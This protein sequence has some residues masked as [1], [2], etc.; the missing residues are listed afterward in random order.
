MVVVAG[1]VKLGLILTE[2]VG[3]VGESS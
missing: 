3:D 1:T 2:Q